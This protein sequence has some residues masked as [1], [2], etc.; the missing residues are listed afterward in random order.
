[1]ACFGPWAKTFKALPT[2]DKYG[3]WAG[4]IITGKTDAGLDKIRLVALAA[5]RPPARSLTTGCLVSRVAVGEKLKTARQVHA[6]F[7]AGLGK[8]IEDVRRDGPT[9][10][11]I[12][13]DFNATVL[14]GVQTTIRPEDKQLT[15][16]CNLHGLVIV[17]FQEGCATS[18]FHAN[19]GRTEEGLDRQLDIILVSTGL[20]KLWGKEL[21]EVNAVPGCA[22]GHH[23]LVWKGGDGLLSWL[24]LAEGAAAHA[25]ERQRHREATMMRLERARRLLESNS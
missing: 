2:P 25:K 22:S 12:Q 3:R 19:R 24:G 20:A 17:E 15:Q 7:Y 16:W 10:F 14:R 23:G 8:L 11:I 21:V 5:Y 18:T 9:E 13:G 1:M 6:A 4:G